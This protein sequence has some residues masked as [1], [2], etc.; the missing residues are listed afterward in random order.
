M[1]YLIDGY[2]LCFSEKFDALARPP[3]H[4]KASLEQMRSLLENLLVDLICCAKQTNK[5]YRCIFDSSQGF[6]IQSYQL[7]PFLRI[8]FS[9]GGLCADRYIWEIVQGYSEK[10]RKTLIVVSGDTGLKAQCRDLGAQTL[11]ASAFFE[12][13]L[14]KKLK[15]KSL[16]LEKEEGLFA[17]LKNF[18][19][20]TFEKKSR[21]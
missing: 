8:S 11:S 13:L 9:P 15:H 21:D 2:N 3:S 17:H 16:T 18:Y 4:K 1:E 6:A 14:E 5:S 20:E 19:T 7:T 10:R 12:Q